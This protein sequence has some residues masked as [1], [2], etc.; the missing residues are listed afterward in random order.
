MADSLRARLLVWFAAIVM[1]VIA[2]VGAA[3]CW[4]TWRSR[5]SAIDAELVRRGESIA[6]AVR[7]GPE[8]RVDV[9]LPADVTAYF[10]RPDAPAYYAVWRA[11]GSIVD[12]S[13]PDIAPD[14]PPQA[15]RFHAREQS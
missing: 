11:D 2:M 13:D 5:L 7:P 8:G 6:R 4:M 1:L 9:E 3:V 15:W 12:R 14:G 10:Q